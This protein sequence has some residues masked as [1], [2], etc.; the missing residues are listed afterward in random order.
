MMTTILWNCYYNNIAATRKTHRQ[1]VLQLL[2]RATA[3]DDS[4]PGRLYAKVQFG[5]ATQQN[6]CRKYWAR[7]HG[8]G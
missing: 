1:K 8:P 7:R 6:E 4:E 2:Y 5:A 3:F